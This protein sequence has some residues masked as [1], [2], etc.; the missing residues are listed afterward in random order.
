MRSAR[1]GGGGGVGVRS[2]LI[3]PPDVQIGQGIRVARVGASLYLR[4]IHLY[5]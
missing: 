3:N 1:A 4:D 5:P 2:E